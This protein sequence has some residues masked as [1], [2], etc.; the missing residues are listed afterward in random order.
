MCVL[1]LSG[2]LL[3]MMWN[4]TTIVGIISGV[5]SCKWIIYVKLIVI[6][7]CI[8]TLYC[9]GGYG[10]CN[11]YDQGIMSLTWWCGYSFKSTHFVNSEFSKKLVQ[12]SIYTY[13]WLSR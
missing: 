1:G 11:I 13:Q 12:I 5:H 10:K 9:Y 6:D 8:G 2:N 3:W 7:L 4:I